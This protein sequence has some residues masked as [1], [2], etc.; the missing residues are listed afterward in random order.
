MLSCAAEGILL[1]IIGVVFVGV[2]LDMTFEKA[3]A[4]ASPTG[5][6]AI[7]IPCLGCSKILMEGGGNAT[8]I[9]SLLIETANDV[10]GW[11]NSGFGFG[12]FR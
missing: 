12:T 9:S 5:S 10:G 11:Y 1:S 7:S 6:V 8:M 3:C 2:S 4:C